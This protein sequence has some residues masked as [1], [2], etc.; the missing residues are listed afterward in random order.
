[1]A[2]IAA[3]RPAANVETAKRLVAE[4]RLDEAEAMLRELL[5]GAPH[6]PEVLFLL[7]M[8]A[9]A[10]G[11]YAEAIARLRA[12]LEDHPGAARVRLELGRAFFLSGDDANAE[13]QFQLALAQKLPA[14][15]E[16]NVQKYLAAIR[17]RRSWSLSVSMAF[18]PDSN[19]NAATGASQVDIYGLPF[20]L[21]PDA[22]RHSGAGLAVDLAGEW[23][24][25]LGRTARLRLGATADAV[26]YGRS[27]FDDI[28]ATA[29]AGPSKLGDRWQASALFV[30]TRRWYGG[31]VY[32]EGPGG[33]LEGAYVP[34]AR[35]R[36]DASAELQRLSYRLNP[37][38]SGTAAT[39]NASALYAL[40]PASLVHVAAWASRLGARD[41][42]Y[43][44]WSGGAAAGYLRELPKGFSVSVEPSI[45]RTVYD[46]PLAAFGAVR[47]D[48][49]FQVSVG[50]LNRRLHWR[51]LA[52]RVAV[53]WADNRSS[54]P[55]YGFSRLRGELRLTR[56]F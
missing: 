41:P 56:Q 2:P 8:V 32:Y 5:A 51:G 9:E 23:S 4:N 20:T 11:Q 39:L 30:G 22:R 38:Q 26:V 50:L 34:T 46:R 36:L 10:K 52:P 28:T 25:R 42:A 1:M 13:R 53:V 16:G 44:Y 35:L 27:D 29:Y 47:R 31:Q 48:T 12:I 6:D 15:V 33:R 55:L 37:G 40:D 19:V 17:A 7:A 49:T 18:A 3:P 21:S 24:P 54:I 45:S 43:G 14:G